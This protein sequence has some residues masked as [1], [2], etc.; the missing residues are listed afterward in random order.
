MA[1]VMGYGL[2]G[3]MGYERAFLVQ[4]NNMAPQ[5]SMG[6]EGFMGYDSYVLNEYLRLD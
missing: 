2:W 5:K 3:F 4:N 1:Q 6:Y